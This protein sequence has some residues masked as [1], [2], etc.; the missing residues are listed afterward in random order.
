MARDEFSG[1]TARTLAQRAG[2]L[3]SNPDCR[4]MTIGP[5]T[6]SNK[7][8][9]IGVAC[10]ICAAS[11]GGPRFDPTQ[12]PEDRQSIENGIWLCH[13]CSDLIDKDVSAHP[14]DLL[15]NWKYRHEAFVGEGGPGAQPPLVAVRTQQGLEMPMVGSL[16]ESDGIRFRDHVLTI[17]NYTDA[18][19]HDIVLPIQ[20]PEKILEHPHTQDSPVGST[21]RCTPMYGALSITRPTGAVE[22]Q[23]TPGGCPEY[24]IEIDELRPAKQ[25]RIRLRTEVEVRHEITTIAL[26]NREQ[27]Y[28]FYIM[29]SYQTVWKERTRQHQLF[30]HLIYD[31][32]TRT[33]T[34]TFHSAVPGGKKFVLHRQVPAKAT[35]TLGYD[36]NVDGRR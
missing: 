27:E 35:I 33:V 25:I 23:A 14:R 3:C 36:E 11:L 2:Y 20:F 1:L 30:V 5:H 16:S 32:A 31:S 17:A 18:V 6:L 7:S 22:R 12:R 24:S 13:S 8:V 15:L 19:L 34:S 21:I 10:H 9:S 4:R 29:G 26:N 28:R